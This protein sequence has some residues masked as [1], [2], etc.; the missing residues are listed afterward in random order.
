MPARSIRAKR[1]TP[2]LR[3]ALIAM[4]M[5]AGVA[6][7]LAAW[8]AATFDPNAWKPYLIEQV[9]QRYQRTLTLGGDIR[10]SWFPDIGATVG[11]VSLSERS[12]SAEFAGA[13]QLRVS[14]AV[15]PLLRGRVVIREITLSQ[16]R[17]TLIIGKDGSRNIDDLLQPAGRG[18]AAAAAD[19]ASPGGGARAIALDIGRI[20]IDGARFTL[21]D[22]RSGRLLSVSALDLSTGR[23]GGDSTEAFNLSAVLHSGDPKVDLRVQA[24]GRLRVDLQG[25]DLGAGGLR[26]EVAGTA[27][28][29]PVEATLD[30]ARLSSGPG[31]LAVEKLRL[32]L[33]HGDAR[34]SVALEIGL[35]ALQATDRAFSRAALA[36]VADYRAGADTLNLRAAAALSGRLSADGPAV[37]Y[38]EAD[39]MKADLEGR[40]GGHTVQAAARAKAIFDLAAGRHA[41]ERH[42]LKATVFGLDM[43]ARDVTL[44]LDG[45]ASG[46][47][48]SG[49]LEARADGRLNETA[50]RARVSRSTATAPWV[51]DIEAGQLDID[52]YRR[53]ATA[54]ARPAAVAGAPGKPAA[55]AIDF[56][57]LE[58]LALDGTVRIGKLRVAGMHAANVRVDLKAARGRLDA[59]PV[60]AS[61]YSGRLE[62][63]LSLV[64]A[65]PPR[66]V[67][68][69]RLSAVQIGPLLADAA[70]LDLLEGRGD[71]R[72][73]VSTQGQSAD[74]MRRALAGTASISLANGAL[75]GVSI[76]DV[77]S[78]ART[79]IAELRG[80]ESRAASA[81]ERTGFSDLKASFVLREGVARSSDLA[82][83]S[84]LLR[85]GGEGA[86]DIGSGTIDY[87][88]RPTLV[89]TLRGEGGRT[90]S[91][92]RGLTV[93]LRITG[94][95][96]APRYGLE[97][98][99]M[100]AGAARDE[101]QR[102]AAS[103]LQARPGSDKGDAPNTAGQR[104]SGS[105]FKGLLGR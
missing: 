38:V 19:P 93:P 95:V 69:Q 92:L 99:A 57:F 26:V 68:R 53:A 9:A 82:L 6:I 12:G 67:L 56:G 1:A 30:A 102:R 64:H 22:E 31:S 11:A 80:R 60:V 8:I 14:L 39:E 62:G 4:G 24:R 36:L 84:P 63:D 97:L 96:S 54:D 2:W 35:P 3:R 32:A 85:V 5:L 37:T 7:A 70:K 77:L 105:I 40:V 72:V 66:L 42:S 15:L 104:E 17:A 28:G 29:V 78:D 49:L 47:G 18:T 91:E 52:R 81:S 48:P 27:G 74:A 44:V 55:P 51:F 34:R 75:R 43:P 58:G 89:G 45:A 65:S 20:V 100:S 61:L 71:I 46:G 86:I 59:S 87:L 101:L 25:G 10:I 41:I 90:G 33:R 88:L 50:L 98:P 79:R 76:T 13:D 21:H 73:E 83:R 23:I 94:P 103:L 16:P